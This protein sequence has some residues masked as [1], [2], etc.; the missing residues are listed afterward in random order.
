MFDIITI[1]S[2]TRD[3]FLAGKNFKDNEEAFCF[4]TGSKVEVDDIVFATGGGGTNAAATFASLGLKCA[5]VGKVGD[6]PGGQASLEDLKKFGVTTKF[7][8][9]DPQQHTAYSIIISAPDKDR[10]ILVYRGASKKLS[11]ADVPFS[12]LKT[13]WLY[14]TSIG[15]NT[16]LLNLLTKFAAENNIKIAFNPGSRELEAGLDKLKYIIQETDVLFLNQGEAAKLTGCDFQDT[17]SILAKLNQVIVKGTVVITRGSEGL[18]VSADNKRYEA[19]ILGGEAVERSGAGDAFG[20][21]FITGLIM[22][23]SI[24]YAIQLGSANAT[25]VIQ[26][27]GTKNGLLSKADLADIKKVEVTVIKK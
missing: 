10:A 4:A 24:E 8:I 18:V 3:V 20:S 7:I 17:D 22:K 23:D 26:Y 19:G 21:G 14:I 6:D 5:C 25:S 2:A 27:V 15:G 12:K 16:A 9:K 11:A 13:K 1:G